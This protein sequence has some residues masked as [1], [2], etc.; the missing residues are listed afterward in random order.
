M[1]SHYRILDL[2]DDDA[3]LE[4]AVSTLDAVA[5][6]TRPTAATQALYSMASGRGLGDVVPNRVSCPE[7]E[8]AGVGYPCFRSDALRVVMN[9]TEDRS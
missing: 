6:G 3:L 4:I 2:T 9:I 5:N 1:L 8:D 7:A